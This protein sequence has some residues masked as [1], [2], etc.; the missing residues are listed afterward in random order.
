[1]QNLTALQLAQEIKK[2][3]FTCKQAAEFSLLKAKQNKYNAFINVNDNALKD[4]ENFDKNKGYNSLLAG[5]PISIKDNICTKGITTTAASDIIKD[6]MPTYNATVI[7]KLIS[8]GMIISAKTNLDEFA[9]GSTGE[10]SAFGAAVNPHNINCVAGGSS[11][12]SAA[13][14][15]GLDSFCS[16]ASDT[17]GSVRIPASYCGVVG[18]KPSYGRV[19]RWGLIAYASSLDQIGTITKTVT[20]AAALFD[21]IKGKDAKDS[22]SIDYK[23]NAYDNLD[24]S[25]KGRKIGVIKEFLDEKIASKDVIL[26]VKKAVKLLKQQGAEVEYVSL[27]YTHLTLSTYYIISSAQV[28]SNLSRFDGIGYGVRAQGE[29]T[30]AIY[31]NTRTNGF[32]DEVKKRILLGNF[33]LSSNNYEKYYLKALK[34]SRLIKESYLN[35]FKSC[36]ALICPTTPT[37]APELN[38][39]KIIDNTD[40][41]TAGVNLAGLSAISIPCAKDKSDMPIGVQIITNSN[42]DCLCLNIANVLQRQIGGNYEL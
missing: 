15:S 33:I 6:F 12:G 1:M 10:N 22:T 11:S 35:L 19:S 37:T 23:D 18:F 42:C 21:I 9:I 29:D 30:G 40:V 14:V 13:A 41:F 4:A 16:L 27:D 39:T 7:D 5:V 20:D 38:D 8:A 3:N 32:G 36:D 26:S 28:S 31:Y 17:G 24:N 34:I 2:G 25:I